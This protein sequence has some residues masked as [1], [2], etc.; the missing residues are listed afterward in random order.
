MGDKPRWGGGGTRGQASAGCGLGVGQACARENGRRRRSGRS[1]PQPHGEVAKDDWALVG[2]LAQADEERPGEHEHPVSKQDL[3]PTCA[4]AAAG[5]ARAAVWAPRSE[6][7]LAAL[8]TR[9]GHRTESR[10]CE[11]ARPQGR[12]RAKATRAPGAGRVAALG[13]V[14]RR[15]HRSAP[16]AVCLAAHLFTTNTVPW[17]SAAAFMAKIDTGNTIGWVR[18]RVRTD[19]RVRTYACP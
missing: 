10:V 6:R 11:M 17:T 8:R 13:V 19:R 9:R 12:P 15:P 4:A 3:G 16:V 1:R 7:P 5:F 2:E 14:G 18:V